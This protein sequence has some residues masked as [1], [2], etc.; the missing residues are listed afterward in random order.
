[1]WGVAVDTFALLASTLIGK[2]AMMESP[3]ELRNSLKWNSCFWY[4]VR[5]QSALFAMLGHCVSN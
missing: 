5:G 4:A 3:S 2:K 1:M